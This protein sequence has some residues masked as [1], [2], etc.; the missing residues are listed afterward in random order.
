[1]SASSCPSI[2]ICGTPPHVFF[3]PFSPA[4]FFFFFFLIFEVV[5]CYVAHTGLKF[6]IPLLFLLTF[7]PLS[8]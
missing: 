5:S 7:Q 3:F 4:P 8:L 1:M 6:S 2:C